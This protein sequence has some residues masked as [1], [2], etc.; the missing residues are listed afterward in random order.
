MESN[1]T[2]Q[3]PE[4]R[5][6]K[7]NLLFLK[8]F[9]SKNKNIFN[10]R[11][12][13]YAFNIMSQSVVEDPYIFMRCVLYI[14]NVRTT[15]EQEIIY[16]TIMHFLCTMFPDFLMNNIELL[17]KLG[18]NDDVLYIIQSKVLTAKI[19]TQINHKIKIDKTETFIKLQNGEEINEKIKRVIYYK[20]KFNKN[21]NQ[22]DFLYKILDEPKLNGILL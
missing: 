21:Y 9:F 7:Y 16:K 18:K 3:Q 4:P 2:I 15:D 6:I 22:T 1:T 8:W 13:E 5:I 19:L 20:P 10:E 11:D 17:L 14:A 12:K